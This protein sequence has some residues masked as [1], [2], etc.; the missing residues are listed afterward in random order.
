MLEWFSDYFYDPAI[1]WG[2]PLALA[3]AW[4]GIRHTRAWFRRHGSPT[5]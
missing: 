4:A 3:L 2:V 1:F 5:D